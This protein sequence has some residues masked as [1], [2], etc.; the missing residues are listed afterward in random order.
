MVAN[1][2][3]SNELPRALLSEL[4]WRGVAVALGLAVVAALAISPVF[5]T[6]LP[7]LLARTAFLALWMVGIYALAGQWPTRWLPSWLPR[8]A[9]QLVAVAVAGPLATLAIYLFTYDGGLRGVFTVPGRFQG[10]LII[11]SLALL[12]GLI[13]TP[14]ALLRERDAHARSQALRFELERERLEKQAVDA[15]LSLLQAQ[16]EPHFLF[17]TL[18]N[19]QALV[20]QGS[21][22]APAVLASLIAYLRAAMPRLHGQ[23]PTLGDEI[24]LVRAYLELMQMRMPD[25]LQWTVD[26][27]PALHAVPMPPMTLLTLVENAVRHGIDPAEQGGRIEVGGRAENDGGLRLWVHDDGVG[28]APTAGAGTGLRN[29]RERLAMVYG[30]RARLEL[31]E[32]PPHGL[33][34]TLH[35]P[36]RP[37]PQEA[38]GDPRQEP[39]R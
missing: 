24:A 12:L 36:P 30:G 38:P 35:L 14:L 21:P 17:N 39:A 8:G 1:T 25:R 13:L 2:S 19:V 3:A 23:A 29:L 4:S 11:G 6:P 27:D 28:M 10:L 37:L 32:P 16:I 34:A 31:D 26:V 22:R 18:A 33:R 15:R 7:V 20:E 5:A 9:V